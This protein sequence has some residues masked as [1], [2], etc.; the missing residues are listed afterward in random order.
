[1]VL[2][3]V[4][5]EELEEITEGMVTNKL[6]SAINFHSS[7]QAHDGHWPGDYGGP[8]FLMPGLVSADLFLLE[9]IPGRFAYLV[10]DRVIES[11]LLPFQNLVRY[12]NA[13]K[14]YFVFFT[15][16]FLLM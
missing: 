16:F 1:M 11:F 8:M 7:L 15:F 4:K 10:C 3:Q 12:I 14:K 5:V 13:E 2:P 6:Q 9:D